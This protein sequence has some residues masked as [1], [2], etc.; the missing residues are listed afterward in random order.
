MNRFSV[1]YTLKKH[2]QHLTFNTRAEAEDALKKLSRHRRGVAIGIYDA[3][4]ELFF[5]E[6]NRQKKYSQLSFSEQAQEDNTM[7]AIVQN[8]R[9][10]AEIASDENHVDLDI[11]LRPMPRLV[12]S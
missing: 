7:I 1:L 5:W 6:P 8:L 9:L 4:T 10:Q 12:H 11:M 2:H 3:K